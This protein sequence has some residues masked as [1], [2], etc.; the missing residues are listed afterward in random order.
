MT[1]HPPS[2]TGLESGVADDGPRYEWLTADRQAQVRNI[3]LGIALFAGLVVF[4]WHSLGPPARPLALAAKLRVVGIMTWL[5]ALV[6]IADMRFWHSS[7]AEKRRVSSGIPES[8]IAWLF[9][10]MLACFG[11]VYYG[12]TED[13][14][15]YAAG[16]ALLL[17][18]FVAFP[19]RRD[20]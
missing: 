7:I 2:D 11:I 8:V 17:A 20:D 4:V 14:R 13:V 12:V 9:G 10:Q 5:Y 16:L 3:L 6:Q 15:W 18:T 19:I 1:A